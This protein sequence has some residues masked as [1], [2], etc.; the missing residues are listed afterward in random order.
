MRDM[1]QLHGAERESDRQPANIGNSERQAA[2][3]WDKGDGE[4]QPETIGDSERH[5]ATPWNQKRQRETC[6][7]SMVL[8]ET[9][10]NYHKRQ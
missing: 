6:S 2:T 1:Q 5:I 8:V 10:S 4:G 7:N 9:T 3:P